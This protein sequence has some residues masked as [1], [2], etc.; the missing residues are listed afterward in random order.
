MLFQKQQLREKIS[1]I[2]SISKFITNPI[3]NKIQKTVFI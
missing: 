2:D 1:H 3:C